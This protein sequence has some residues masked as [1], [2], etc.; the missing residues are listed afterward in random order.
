MQSL[1]IREAD[2]NS[3]PD[4]RK[5]RDRRA[6]NCSG[7]LDGAYNDGTKPSPLSIPA[8]FRLYGSIVWIVLTSAIG[9]IFVIKEAWGYVAHLLGHG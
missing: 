9:S 5:R 6:S 3:I 7:N 8:A 4:R 2:A 1:R